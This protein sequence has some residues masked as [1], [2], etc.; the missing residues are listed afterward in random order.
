MKIFLT[1]SD[2]EIKSGYTTDV[3]F[4]RTEKILKEKGMDK[5]NVVAEV[6]TGGLPEGKKWGILTGVI[7]VA[8]LLEGYKVNFYSMPEGSFF[9]SNDY[10]GIREPVAFIEGP[11]IEFCKL[12]TPLLGFLCQSSGVSTKAAHIRIKAWG[13]LLIAFGARRMHPAISP[14]LDWATYVGGFD[15]VSTLK[16]ASVI[17]AEP[18]G[19]MPHSL[20][21]VFGSQAEAWKS[22]DEVMPEKVPRIMLVDT[23]WD[24]KLEALEAAKLLKNKLYGVRLDTPSSRR[25]NMKEIIREVKWELKSRGYENVKIIVSGGVD[26][27]N[28]VDYIE[29]G[30]DGFGVGTSVSNAPTIDFALDIVEVNGKP[31]SKRGKFSGKKQVWRCM[32]CFID[33]VKLWNEEEPKCPKCGKR[34]KKMLIGFIK[35]GVISEK[36]P[37]AKESREYVLKQLEI[38]KKFEYE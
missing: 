4:E 37:S 35:N 27:D 38:I 17:N 2:E 16:G 31:I 5:V 10:Y 14:M 29:A 15:G 20:I 7:E 8:K 21:I 18:T 19:T 12:E 22:F 3:Y 9:R 34:M 30:A 13:K 11:Y 24:E 32:D 33:I 28:I 23:F 25:G 36:L 26:E 6:T 1:A